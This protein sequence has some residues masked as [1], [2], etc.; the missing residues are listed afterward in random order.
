MTYF[1]PEI[2]CNGTDDC[3][4]GFIC[5]K[6]LSNPWWGVTNF[7]NLMN[8]F[9]MVFQVTTME[10]WTIIMLDMQRSFT[11]LIILY[12]VLLVFIGNFFLLNLL[13]AVIIIKFNEVSRESRKE[14]DIT[15]F[16]LQDINLVF[17]E[18]AYLLKKNGFDEGVELAVM[19]LEGKQKFLDLSRIETFK[20][21]NRKSGEINHNALV[22][23]YLQT[24]VDNSD[25]DYVDHFQSHR[26]RK[27]NEF[28][29]DDL[30]KVE[31]FKLKS[32]EGNSLL[33][34]PEEGRD[35][36]GDG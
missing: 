22:N 15:S 12:F 6:Q 33:K 36:P 32:I 30:K 2:I 24:V 14:T 16:L 7:D 4:G 13:L 31:L 10:G 18:H 25:K 26:F 28:V 8:S 35:V 3:P 17:P 29:I 23:L 5:G 9:L 20:R 19:K 1:Y 21:V 27:G 34:N 11:S